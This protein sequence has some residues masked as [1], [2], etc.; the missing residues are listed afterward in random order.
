MA[1]RAR[2]TPPLFTSTPHVGEVVSAS[3]RVSTVNVADRRLEAST[4]LTDGYG[5]ARALH[6]KPSCLPLSN[7][8]KISK[9]NRIKGIQV[10][11]EHGTPFLAAT[12][13][14]D[15][16]PVPRKWLALSRTRDASELFVKQGAILVTRSGNVGRTTV[17]FDTHE[18]M[19]ISDDLLRV[20]S[21]EEG[22][23]GWLYA[24]LRASKT[25]LM[26]RSAH[27]GHMIKHLEPS[28][29]N[30]LPIPI[31]SSK[32]YEECNVA[33]EEI[34]ACRNEAF[35]LI[36][37]AEAQYAE[38]VSSCPCKVNDVGFT[39]ASHSLSQRRR[40]LD[41][42]YHCP[43]ILGLRELLRSVGDSS[44]TLRD[45]GCEAWLPN[46]F[47]RIPATEGVELVSSSALFEISP[48][49]GR[50]I[51]DRG[52]G[53]K[54]EGRVSP[55]WLLIARSG[56]IYGLVGSVTLANESHSNRVMSDHVIRLVPSKDGSIRA[57]YLLVALSHPT[58]GRPLMKALP[59]GSSI[60]SIDVEDV[61][62][63]CIPRFP[64]HAEKSISD[65]TVKAS[66]LHAKANAT[67][68]SMANIADGVISAI[69]G[70]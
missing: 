31:T 35:K 6:A 38:L 12:Q 34:L 9:P 8:A 65:L 25:R 49:S 23:S 18:G 17:A 52:F 37:K 33:L 22:M 57:G 55:G 30:G 54:H 39:I 44:G 70:V 21:I 50:R 63:L 32:I 14:F 45:F 60:P 47:L 24:Y 51:A 3:V 15:T 40:R 10:S 41:A 62:D 20:S 11:E 16:R 56:Q 68:L 67:E 66:A 59:T 69:M 1:E 5:I 2:L 28:H 36:G 4:Y 53:D 29:L 58:L 61:L 27:Y 7:V 64:D 43:E 19:L 26:M 48:D 13:V 42:A 46:R